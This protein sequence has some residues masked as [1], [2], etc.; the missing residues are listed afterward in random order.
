MDQILSCPHCR[1]NVQVSE[2]LLGK[3]VKCP[4]C[5]S[6]FVVSLPGPPASEAVRPADPAWP[7]A[8]A[9]PGAPAPYPRPVPQPRRAS[10]SEREPF[11]NDRDYEERRVEP[12][13]GSTVLTLGILSLVVCGAL[14][15]IAWVMGNT[16][17]GKIR[18][19]LM[20]PEGEGLTR[21]G[22]ICGIIASVLL[23]I[24]FAI[25]IIVVIF[26]AAAGPGRRGF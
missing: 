2:S 9:A 24:A 23:M 7:E 15:P 6:A 19:G 4:V 26:A 17:L 3:N 18:Q 12:H 10:M 13:R 21:A 11:D 20:D 1:E 16:D 25:I 14:G 8:P 5:G 22:Q